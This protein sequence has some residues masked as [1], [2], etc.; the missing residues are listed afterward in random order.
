MANQCPHN[1]KTLASDN[2]LLRWNCAL[3]YLVPQVIYE[4]KLCKLKVCR[5]CQQS[6]QAD[7]HRGGLIVMGWGSSIGD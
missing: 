5:D 3:C 1:Y 7:S 6:S 2:S 4:C